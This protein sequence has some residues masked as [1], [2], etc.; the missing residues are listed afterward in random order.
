MITLKKWRYFRPRSFHSVSNQAARDETVHELFTDAE[1]IADKTLKI[2]P[3]FDEAIDTLKLRTKNAATPERLLALTLLMLPRAARAQ[4]MMDAHKHNFHDRKL[5]LFELIDFN[6]KFV[7]TVLA[8]TPAERLG[9]AD[10]LYHLMQHFSKQH[11]TPNFYEGQYQAIVHG[12]SREI[13]VYLAAIDRGYDA[14][15]T[16]RTDDAFGVD[17]Q[18]RDRQTR[19]YIN[20]D[21]KTRSS[22]FFRLKVLLRERRINA[23]EAKV[24][25]EIGYCEVMHRTDEVEVPVVLFRIDHTILG[26]ISNFEFTSTERLGNKIATV[27]SRHGIH[28]SG[29]GKVIVPL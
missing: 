14:L 29:Y 4:Q 12:L 8:L 17:M 21:C 22:Y 25:L 1:R 23:E 2:H 10:R 15:M 16:S 24:A 11:K 18:I 7:S 9:F 13:A 19:A 26:D 6:D 3:T 5:R 20:I 28:D 27:M